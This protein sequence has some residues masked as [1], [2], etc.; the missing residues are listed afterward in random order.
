MANALSIV[1]SGEIASSIANGTI[2]NTLK[3]FKTS[4]LRLMHVLFPLSIVLLFSSKYI[5]QFLFTDVFE[6]SYRIFNIY[7]LLTVCRLFFPQTILLGLQHNRSILAASFV[8]LFVNAILGYVLMIRFG[9]YAVPFAT[10]AAYYFN[11]VYL[12]IIVSRKGYQISDYT[13][14]GWWIFYSIALWGSYF[15]ISI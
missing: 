13:N 1:I 3:K 8:E 12:Y 15:L 2:K 7:L 5:Y 14:I 6:L 11:Q 4:S 10:L 9:I